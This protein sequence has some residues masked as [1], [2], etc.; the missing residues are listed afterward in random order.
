[1]TQPKNATRRPHPVLTPLTNGQAARLVRLA[2]AAAAKRG[3]A[4][5]YDGFGALRPINPDGTGHA[6]PDGPIAGLGNLAL[7]VAGL[8]R[9][10]WR[11]VVA[12]HFDQMPALDDLLTIP[13]DLESKL[14]LRLICEADQDPLVVRDAPRFVPGVVTVPALQTGRAVT[15]YFDVDRLG[16]STDEARRIGLANLRRLNDEQVEIVRFSRAEF[17]ILR[18]GMFTASRALVLDTVLREV[19]RVERPAHGCLVA[20]PSRNE[21]AVH[22]LRDPTVLDAFAGM[23]AYAVELFNTRPGAVS[24]HVYYVSGT[25]WHQVTDYSDGTFRVHDSPQLLEAME[26]LGVS[27]TAA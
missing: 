20:M 17:T 9:Q 1:M 18:G 21:L 13:D 6:P 7:K 19:L 16:L 8:P 11:A 10:Q 5:R 3:L 27:L 12:D 23:A 14:C 22:V 4:L 15:M 2:E 26:Q 24:P 25:E